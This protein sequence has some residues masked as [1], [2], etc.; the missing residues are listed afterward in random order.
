MDGVL[1]LVGSREGEVLFFSLGWFEEREEI[2]S[3]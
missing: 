3:G 2:E 1:V